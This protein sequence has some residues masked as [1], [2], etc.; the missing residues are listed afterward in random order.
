[1]YLFNWPIRD[2]LGLATAYGYITGQI[3]AP[4]GSRELARIK[5]RAES[6]SFFAA[7]SPQTA[8]INEPF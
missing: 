4:S 3:K 2:R 5:K 6:F 8:I 1:M 7:L